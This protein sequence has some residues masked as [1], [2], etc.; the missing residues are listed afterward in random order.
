MIFVL[1]NYFV[2]CAQSNVWPLIFSVPDTGVAEEKS[3]GFFAS[4]DFSYYKLL[5]NQNAAQ[6]IYDNDTVMFE[7]NWKYDLTYTNKTRLKQYYDLSGCVF[8]NFPSFAQSQIGLGWTP[9]ISYRSGDTGKFYSNIDIGPILRMNIVQIPFEVKGGVVGTGWNEEILGKIFSEHLS[10]FHGEPGFYGG[11][12]IGDSL[13]GIANLPL[14]VNVQAFG[15]S[16]NQTRSGMVM[17]TVLFAH[18]LGS[19]DSLFVYAGDS[20]LN[21]KEV[22][23]SGKSIGNS[24]SLTPPW[25]INN[26]LHVS[27]GLK[28][29]ERLGFFPAAVYTLQ[30]SSVEYPSKPGYYE[31]I[32]TFSQSVNFLLM[33][34]DK[35][36][37]DYSGG[38]SFAG[39]EEDRFF[40]NGNR[41]PGKYIPKNDTSLYLN[42]YHSI[43]AESD[44]ELRINFPLGFAAEYS[45]HAFKDSK[46]YP[47][48]YIAPKDSVTNPDENDHIRIMHHAGLLVDSL[49]GFSARVYG[50]YGKTYF[51]YYRAIMSGT[52]NEKEN[53]RIGIDAKYSGKRNFTIA[54]KIFCEADVTEFYFK[55]NDYKR[56]SSLTSISLPPISLPPYSRRLS[57]VLSINWLVHKNVNFFGSWTEI[58]TDN[59]QW[60]SREYFDSS[61]VNFQNDSYAVERKS[62]NYELHFS[63]ALLFEKILVRAG[64]TVSDI[65]ERNFDVESGDYVLKNPK[66]GYS[67]EPVLSFKLDFGFLQAQGRVRKLIGTSDKLKETFKDKWDINL[68][69]MV[70]F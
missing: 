17:G 25:R 41:N 62:V 67:L 68:N 51:Y 47:V 44:H 56:D 1:S 58:C 42:D 34:G 40:R 52:S 20:L 7:Q 48:L 26:I 63:T 3:S 11:G 61:K 49:V 21:G 8:R 19:G 12:R 37:F 22:F 50:E 2:V 28:G 33:T 45:L 4:N 69:T 13:R 5:E 55:Y 10:S 29:K 65:F 43:G 60:Y 36:F 35:F 46:R 23:L 31:D 39:G 38:I 59:G 32:R 53:Y 14:F 6:W 24:S 18:E 66:K 70:N 57:S 9:E 30:H 27:G 64:G 15:K 16:V 54:E